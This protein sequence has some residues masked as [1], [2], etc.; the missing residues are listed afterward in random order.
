LKTLEYKDDD[1]QITW[2]VSDPNVRFGSAENIKLY[3]TLDRSKIKSYI[4]H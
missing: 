1:I 2:V 3:V 4:K